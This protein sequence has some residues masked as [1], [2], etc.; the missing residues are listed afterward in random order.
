MPSLGFSV[1]H[2]TAPSLR[3]VS[4]LRATAKTGG[5]V[6]FVAGMIAL[7][8]LLLA[9]GFFHVQARALIVAFLAA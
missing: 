9:L 6:G 2:K 8:L 4:K 3:R 7:G 1:E 5:D